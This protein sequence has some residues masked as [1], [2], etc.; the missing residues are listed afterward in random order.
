MATAAAEN[1]MSVR[2]IDTLAHSL[3]VSWECAAAV[4]KLRGTQEWS[5]DKEDKLIAEDGDGRV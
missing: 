5:Q 3:G 2:G 1:R 4:W